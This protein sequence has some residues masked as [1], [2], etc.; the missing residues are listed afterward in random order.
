[1]YKSYNETHTFYRIQG[2]KL[3]KTIAVSVYFAFGNYVEKEV[4][5]I[6]FLREGLLYGMVEVKKHKGGIS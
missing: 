4:S 3:C 1:M 2:V 5:G 6:L